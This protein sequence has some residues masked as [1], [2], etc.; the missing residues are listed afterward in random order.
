MVTMAPPGTN[1]GRKKCLGHVVG[2]VEVDG[3]VPLECGT[4][5]QVVEQEHAGV[6]DEDVQ[7]LDL[8]C[9]FPDLLR[10]GDVQDQ[11][12]DARAEM[13]QR[14]AR[15]GVHPRRA[16]G[17]RLLDQRPADAAAGTGHQDCL[18]CDC[19]VCSSVRRVSVPPVRAS[20][21]ID[22]PDP[23]ESPRVDRPFPGG[24]AIKCTGESC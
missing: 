24:R 2:A 7:R 14:P 8:A 6:V 19:H 23:P 13:L 20:A 12:R 11:R 15:A 5:A 10:A 9:G 3:K 17:E 21:D 18:A 16:P 4:I 1:Q 22:Q